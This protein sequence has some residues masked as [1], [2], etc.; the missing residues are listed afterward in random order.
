MAQ[1]SAAANRILSLRISLHDESSGSDAVT[2][3]DGGA[4]IQFKEVTFKY[5][6]RDVPVFKSLSFTVC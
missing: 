4:K 3:L 1:A 2:D 5:P 6:T